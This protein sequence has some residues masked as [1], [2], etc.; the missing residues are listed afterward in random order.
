MT[1]RILNKIQLCTVVLLALLNIAV[2]EGLGSNTEN[3]FQPV[4]P[5]QMSGI[6]TMIS[7][8]TQSNYDKIKTWQGKVDSTIGTIYEGTKAERVFKNQINGE[9]KVPRKVKRLVETTVEFA[10]NCEKGLFFDKKFYRSPLRYTD[11][12]DGRLLGTKS[13]DGSTASIATPEY[14][15]T[16]VPV[17]KRENV[18][19]RQA[20]KEERA[21]ESSVRNRGVFDPRFEAIDGDGFRGTFVFLLDYIEKHGKFSVGEQSLRI[22]KRMDRSTTEYRIEIPSP[23]ASPG[24]FVFTTLIFNSDKGFNITLSE[25]RYAGKLYQKATWEY[26]VINDVYLPAST[27][28][29]T[30]AGEN[31]ELLYER[32]CIYTNGQLNQA[33]PEDTFSYKNLGLKNGDKFVDKILGKEYIFQDQNLILKSN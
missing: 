13:I 33:I 11:P 18:I 29:Q 32:E 27:M 24:E 20:V 8:E 12:N 5:D 6:L 7:N 3:N 28:I 31:A 9:G 26:E 2:V 22:E 19:T 23:Q 1:E 17:E 16:T 30:F 25:T 15:I 21:S 4:P 10:V 14:R